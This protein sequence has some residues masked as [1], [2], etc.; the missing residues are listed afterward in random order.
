MNR[1]KCKF[2]LATI[3]INKICPYHVHVCRIMTKLIFHFTVLKLCSAPK[4]QNPSFTG[5]SEKQS[6]S[7]YK[8]FITQHLFIFQCFDFYVFPVPCLIWKSIN[9]VQL[10]YTTSH[11]KHNNPK[12]ST[13]RRVTGLS[14]FLHCVHLQVNISLLDAKPKQIKLD[15]GII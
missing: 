2:K 3:P 5:V 13:E 4:H 15:W 6:D 7:Q 11:T 14:E 12:C 8:N 1:K 10:T 9:C